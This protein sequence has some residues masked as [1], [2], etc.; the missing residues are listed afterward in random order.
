MAP[1][2]F[3]A[4]FLAPQDKPPEKCTLSGTVV[5]SVTGDPLNKARVVAQTGSGRTASTFSTTTDDKGRFTLIDL[6]AGVYRLKAQRNRYLDAWYGARRAEGS[7]STITLTPGNEMKSLTIKLPPYAVIAGTVRD[8]DGEPLAKARVY[9]ARS[10]F[11]EGRRIMDREDPV[12]TDD[13]G[14]YRLSLPPGRYYLNAKPKDPDEGRAPVDR[15]PKDAPPRQA[16][17]PAWFP[18]SVD[19]SGA[20]PLEL[21]PGTR[22]SGI[23][24]NLIRS[25]LGGVI[26]HVD[27]PAGMDL[28]VGLRN[29]GPGVDATIQRSGEKNR[30]GDFE[31]RDVPLGSYRLSASAHAPRKDAENGTI[32]FNSGGDALVASMPL[33]VGNSGMERARISLVPGADVAGQV[34]LEGETPPASGLGQ[35]EF[36][37][38]D[39]SRRFYLRKDLKVNL[40]LPRGLYTMYFRGPAALYIKSIRN[41]GREL[42]KEG[43]RIAGSGKLPLEIVL[44]SDTGSVEAAVLD[45]DDKPL[46]GATVV[47][48]P[49]PDLRA[50]VDRYRTCATDQYGRCTVEHVPPGQYKLFAWE[51][52]EPEVW[53]DPEFLKDVESKGEPVTVKSGA[54]ESAKLHAL[55][56]KQ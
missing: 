48:I 14:Q 54:T 44:A 17:I 22:L 2:F 6:D 3:L 56:P 9:A 43:L 46:A 37:S 38:E 40:T 15:S 28:V 32:D 10:A 8:S 34:T 42:I 20:R 23:D 5:D 41:Q 1:L 49:E 13:L 52:A 39:L 51:D 35:I 24:I 7:G 11:Q 12:D 16:L 33:E 30:E 21:T 31:M 19:L 53:F 55:K 27:A 36:S 47:L 18:N 50:R 26:V 25:R 29:G 45:S 4:F